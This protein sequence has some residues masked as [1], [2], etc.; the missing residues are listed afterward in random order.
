LSQFADSQQDL[1]DGQEVHGHGIAHL[2]Q[3]HG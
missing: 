2:R 3:N 1:L